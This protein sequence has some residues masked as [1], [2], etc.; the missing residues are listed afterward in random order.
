MLGVSV[1]VFVVVDLIGGIGVSVVGR[2]IVVV[3]LRFLLLLICV[4]DI[5]PIITIV[6]AV[7]HISVNNLLV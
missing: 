3:V 6:T 5:A 2:L 7:S 4:V 1:P